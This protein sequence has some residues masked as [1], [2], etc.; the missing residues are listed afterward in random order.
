M[1][2]RT[3]ALRYRELPL[4][5]LASC[6]AVLLTAS[7]AV[8]IMSTGSDAA[9][10][11]SVTFVNDSGETLWIGSLAN[12]D[13]S[14][15][16]E[17]LPVLAHG[18]AASLIIPDNN[19]S[20]W[21]GKFF[22]RQRCSGNPGSTF[23]CLVGDCGVSVNRCDHGEQPASLA[24]FNFDR[25][26]SLAPW[27][28][29][30]YV[31]A[32]SLPITIVPQGAD[33]STAAGTCAKGGCSGDEMLAACPAEN[34]RYDQTGERLVCVNPNRDAET[35]YSQALGA[36]QPRA[37]LW[38]THDRVPGSSTV[39]NCAQC[40]EFVV[41][42]HGSGSSGSRAQVMTPP[43]VSQAQQNGTAVE[44]AGHVFRGYVDKCIDVPGAVSADGAQLQL[45][46]CNGTNAQ[47]FYPGPNRSQVILGK[48]M[49]VA[50]A[51]T[52]RGAKVQLAWC[53]GGP[54]QEWVIEGSKLVNPHSGKCVDVRDWNTANGAPLV[55]WDCHGGA[56][57][58][59]SA[60]RPGA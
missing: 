22:A 9:T 4:V 20:Y 43:K 35:A 31:N 6:I 8:V 27:Y 57:Q 3:L 29:V 21:R 49:D 34:A 51:S 14:H 32:L 48:C 45:W 41:T 23:H 26:D 30:S 5:R 15:N 52:E 11:H 24:E 58:A 39:F 18:Q 28:N 47:T 19:P 60:V 53:N 50:W 44:P 54:A 36:Y 55:I 12:T 56:N 7:F 1:L 46:D 13:G 42:F 2:C 59:W 38:S 16:V 40:A 10:E 17:N 25:N 33:P 37:Y